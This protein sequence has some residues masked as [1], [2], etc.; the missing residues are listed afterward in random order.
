MN[1]QW[2]RRGIALT[3]L[4]TLGDCAPASSQEINGTL[5][6]PTAT[7]TID[8]ASFRLRPCRSAA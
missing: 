1:C 8:G 5:G 7:M 6:S 4:M 3:A 2:L